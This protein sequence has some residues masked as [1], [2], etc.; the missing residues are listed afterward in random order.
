[1]R[2]EG[3]PREWVF[4]Q[5]VYALSLDTQRNNPSHKSDHDR[6]LYHMACTVV[7]NGEPM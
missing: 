2:S 3:H 6:L 7:W 1:M 4:Q 5:D